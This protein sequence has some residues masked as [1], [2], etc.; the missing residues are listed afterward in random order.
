[1]I[2]K[3]T[4]SYNIYAAALVLIPILNVGLTSAQ[5]SDSWRL[6]SPANTTIP[7][8]SRDIP[9]TIGVQ[10]TYKLFRNANMKLG[11]GATTTIC[12]LSN[13]AVNRFYIFVPTH[14]TDAA[15]KLAE[16][17]VN[18]CYTG[19]HPQL[20][21]DNDCHVPNF[22]TELCSC[23]H[24]KRFAIAFV[25][26]ST[27]AGLQ[28]KEMQ[29]VW[30][31]NHWVPY[32][33]KHFGHFLIKISEF[34]DLIGD[35][36]IDGA[37]NFAYLFQDYNVTRLTEME[38]F[39]WDLANSDVLHAGMTTPRLSFSS[40]D[41]P[42][43]LIKKSPHWHH[44]EEI[45]EGIIAESGSEVPLVQRNLGALF[46]LDSISYTGRYG[47]FLK[48]FYRWLSTYSQLKQSIGEPGLGVE[49]AAS[50]QTGCPPEK[51]TI[52]F[53]SEHPT[54]RR[55]KILDPEE[56]VIAFITAHLPGIPVHYETVS[57]SS[58]P[59][60]Q[61]KLFNSFGLMISPHGGHLINFAF[62]QPNAAIIELHPLPSVFSDGEF[63]NRV[64]PG[65]AYYYS[66]YHHP[67][68]ALPGHDPNPINADFHLNVTSFHEALIVAKQ[69]LVSVCKG[70]GRWQ[71]LE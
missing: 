36:L 55:R 60:E 20:Q 6:F 61:V 30:M 9:G 34:G 27:F 22:P 62:A 35:G 19:K 59:S 51:I 13:V 64:F 16:C 67:A 10:F 23:T 1:M 29:P 31:A 24:T 42:G 12:S 25:T 37:R 8:I 66:I 28:A 69:H 48:H 49:V 32:G 52:F 41:G 50:D 44:R 5:S 54:V 4:V 7:L 71:L 33:G 39:L 38:K 43:N 63:G 70:T 18:I 65:R 21:H 3:L 15:K 14:S 57:S 53:R 58:S 46:H 11:Y 56:R 45:M 40:N 26:Q 47:Y 68:P 2:F 17:L